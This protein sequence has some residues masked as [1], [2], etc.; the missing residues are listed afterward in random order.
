MCDRFRGEMIATVNLIL[1]KSEMDF[2]FEYLNVNVWVK[3]VEFDVEGNL[4]EERYQI[5]SHEKC[6]VT[7]SVTE[8]VSWK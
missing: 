1:F 3:F 2:F 6:M 8:L 4:V 5:K 7:V